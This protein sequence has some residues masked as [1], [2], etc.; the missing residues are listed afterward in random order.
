MHHFFVLFSISGRWDE[1]LKR[2]SDGRIFLDYDYELIEI[3][4]NHFRE[5]KIEDPSDPLTYPYAP[6]H[7]KKSFERMLQYFGLVDYF[8]PPSSSTTMI[9]SK[10]NFVQYEGKDSVTVTDNDNNTIKLVYKTG[11]NNRVHYGAACTN[12]LDPSGEGCFWKVNIDSLQNNNH[13]FL[14]IL[15]NLDLRYCI[16]SEATSFG[17]EGNSGAICEGQYG[18]KNGWTGFVDGEC[19]YFHFKSNKLSMH[20]VQKNQTFFIDDDIF[21]STTKHYFHINCVYNNTVV[22][23]GPLDAEERKVFTDEYMNTHDTI[24]SRSTL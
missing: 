21:T 12:E 18:R 23:L 3:I 6:L 20:R 2:D 14:G 1:S 4:V 11:G 15:G 13:F 24:Y 10:S 16:H 5:K 9:F 19:L 8:D 7:K 17:W 22:T